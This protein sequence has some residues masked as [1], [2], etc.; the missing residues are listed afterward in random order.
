MS[1][2]LVAETSTWQHTQHS[3]QKYVHAPNGIRTHNLSSRVAPDLRFRLRSHW[4]RHLYL[5]KLL[6]SRIILSQTVSQTEKAGFQL[7]DA[8][9][10][11]VLSEQQNKVLSH[12][13]HDL[14]SGIFLGK[15]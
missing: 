12:L 9:H 11:K 10:T 8:K 15:V 2:Q 3:Q 5:F 13:D 4:D 7:F 1:D 14:S 6:K